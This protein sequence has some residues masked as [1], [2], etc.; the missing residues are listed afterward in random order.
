MNYNILI[1]VLDNIIEF[2][3]MAVDVGGKTTK[4]DLSLNYDEEVLQELSITK[5]SPV[6]TSTSQK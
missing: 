3:V 2:N 4:T 1:Y 6:I 5:H